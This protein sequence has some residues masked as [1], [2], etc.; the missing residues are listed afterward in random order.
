[1][2]TDRQPTEIGIIG[3][4]TAPLSAVPSAKRRQLAAVLGL[5]AV[6]FCAVGA[7][8][9]VG[10]GGAVV[11]VLAAAAFAL[12]LM[13]GLAAAGLL[14]SLRLDA[15]QQ[16]DAEIDASIDA[17]INEALAKHGYQSMCTCGHEHDPTE[18]HIVDA[19]PCAHD[20]FGAACAHDC[21]ACVLTALRPSAPGE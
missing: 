13:N 10:Q 6:L 14:R 7:V 19:E 15:R 4:V 20:G 1:M 3:V 2:R 12:G 18:L 17:A 9:L 21:E 16:A 11:A 8:A 5:F